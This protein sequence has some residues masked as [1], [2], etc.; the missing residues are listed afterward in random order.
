MFSKSGLIQIYQRLSCDDFPSKVDWDDKTSGDDN[1][2]LSI[3]A[4]M[5]W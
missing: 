4:L 3:T 5:V 2:Y 1:S